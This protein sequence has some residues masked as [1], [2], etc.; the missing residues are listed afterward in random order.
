MDIRAYIS[1][2]KL[3]LYLLGELSE[4]EQEEVVKLAATYPE[5]K[6]E[7]EQL[8]D[9]L[10][11]FDSISGPALSAGMKDRVMQSWEEEVNSDSILPK[12]LVLERKEEIT[13]AK[14]VKIAPWKTYAAAASIVA[15][16]ASI[17]AIYF[18][19]RY[20]DTDQRLM[21]LV[22]ERAVLAQE[23]DQYKVNYEQVDG[24]LETLL[25]G[26]FQRVPMKGDGF[27]MQKDAQVDVWWD[28]NAESVFISVNTLNELDENSDYQLWAIGD[29]G[30]VGIGLVNAG[31]KF[32]LQQMQAVAA[33]GAFAITI[34]PKGGSESPTLEK[35]VVLGPVA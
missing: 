7:L 28:Q 27:E 34:E 9:A 12:S 5:I 30:P 31:Q 35:L 8:E 21:A 1:S 18:A 13:E 16:M 17:I 22:E 25:A 32:S 3:E 23:L 10:F 2:G 14:S 20:F 19:N 33:A 6:Q 29:D 26:N 24:Q 15:V 11:A 4:R